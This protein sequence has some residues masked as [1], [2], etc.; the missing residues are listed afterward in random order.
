[1]Y[2]RHQYDADTNH[3]I[4]SLC[5]R[6]RTNIITGLPPRPV[7]RGIPAVQEM[8]NT[9]PDHDNGIRVFTVYIC[10]YIYFF[11]S[12]FHRY[13]LNLFTTYRTMFLFTVRNNN[14]YYFKGRRRVVYNIKLL[15]KNI[16]RP[17]S[18]HEN[19]VYV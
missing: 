10:I 19:A 13:H 2:A 7:V 5:T 16:L 12:R 3:G 8:H 6:I 11:F 9:K 14:V 17:R 1:V 4:R 15:S 18:T